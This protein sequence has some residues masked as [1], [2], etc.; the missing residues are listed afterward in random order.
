MHPTFPKPHY[1]ST[2]QEDLQAFHKMK[3]FGFSI[4]ADLHNAFLHQRQT[5]ELF[6]KTKM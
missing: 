3:I 5:P 4:L 6:W 1:I 2:Q